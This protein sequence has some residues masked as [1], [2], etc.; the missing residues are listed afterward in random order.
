[1]C[2]EILQREELNYFVLMK[3]STKARLPT[4]HK[5]WKNDV[6]RGSPFV[7][8]WFVMS[9]SIST[10]DSHMT[11]ASGCRDQASR[12][13][14]NS[15]IS[16]QICG[17]SLCLIF[18]SVGRDSS[19]HTMHST[20]NLCRHASSGTVATTAKNLASCKQVEPIIQLPRSTRR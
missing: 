20:M 12:Q 4:R 11:V 1:M 18:Y 2:L 5:K 6:K 17:R 8:S 15:T 14:L 13:Q 10:E 19:M 9:A 3:V 16:T 7:A